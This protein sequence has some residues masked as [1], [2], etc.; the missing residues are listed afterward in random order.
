MTKTI[1]ITGATSGIG[2]F[3]SQHYAQKGFKLFLHGRD[4]KKLGGLARK[5]DGTEFSLLEAD[6][7]RPR[8]IERMFRQLA[9]QT[10]KLDVLI[11]NAFGKLEDPISKADPE[12]ITEFFRVSLAGTSEVIKG[13]LPFLKRAKGSHIVNIVADWGFPMH[14]IMTGPSLYI[15]AKY[16]IHGLGV[17]LQTE[18]A[19][20]GIRVTNLC[21][22]I[23]AADTEFGA[24]EGNF[25]K[26]HG[27]QAIHPVDLANAID[28]VMNQRF[29]H[30]RS[31]IL[32]PNNPE[33]NGL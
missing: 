13:S 11:N 21:P 15:A 16:G 14:N 23:V 32:T 31:I 30:V 2:S 8:D 9:S 26:A 18:I 12:R 24:T 10:K 22:G 6:Y 4:G 20:M 7:S 3:L 19:K 17:A 33:Y 25:K 5:L 27:N 28:F 29:S 1:L